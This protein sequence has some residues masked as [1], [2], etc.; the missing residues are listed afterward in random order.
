MRF[1]LLAVDLNLGSDLPCT[2]QL[3]NMAGMGGLG[4]LGGGMGG[5]KKGRLPPLGGRLK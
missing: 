4:S 1:S 5:G 2:L 3:G